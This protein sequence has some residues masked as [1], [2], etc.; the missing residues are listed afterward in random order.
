VSAEKGSLEDSMDMLMGCRVD[1][2]L[3]EQYHRYAREA[4]ALKEKLKKSPVRKETR[5][6]RL[7][8][9]ENVLMPQL[10]RRIE[11]SLA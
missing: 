6:A 11:G 1:V 3:M 2:G 8:N 10:Q 7:N 5:E 9:V 4:E